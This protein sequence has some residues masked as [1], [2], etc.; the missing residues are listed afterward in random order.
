LVRFY[1]VYY[2]LFKCNLRRL[3]D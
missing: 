1:T 2:V 3:A